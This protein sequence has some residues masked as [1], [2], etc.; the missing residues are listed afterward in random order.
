MEPCA[1]R[2][3]AD[4][5]IVFI[6]GPQKT[7]EAAPSLTGLSAGFEIRVSAF[8]LAS[9][10][11][12]CRG[13]APIMATQRCGGHT[14]ILMSRWLGCGHRVLPQIDFG[15][16]PLQPAQARSHASKGGR[17]SPCLPTFR[18]SNRDVTATSNTI[19]VFGRPASKAHTQ[20]SEGA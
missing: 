13:A 18:T 10:R 17:K 15:P 3:P 1:D 11:A 12:M 19:C 16:G 20:P 14:S 2:H 5:L 4:F 8:V 9:A 7:C 6:Q